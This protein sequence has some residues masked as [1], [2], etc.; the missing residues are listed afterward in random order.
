MQDHRIGGLAEIVIRQNSIRISKCQ[1]RF[2]PFVNGF[3]THH[4]PKQFAIFQTDS[5]HI[6][7]P[8]TGLLS[9]LRTGCSATG[10]LFSLADHLEEAL[11][12]GRDHLALQLPRD[13]KQKIRLA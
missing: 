5:P 2:W 8:G 9:H 1:A 7:G 13:H 6:Q 10:Q 12:E 3:M 4:D 11:T